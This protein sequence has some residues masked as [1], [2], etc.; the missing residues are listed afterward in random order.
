MD[1][2][3]FMYILNEIIKMN[4]KKRDY[5]VLGSLTCTNYGLTVINVNSSTCEFPLWTNHGSMRALHQMNTLS[6]MFVD[7]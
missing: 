3:D 2:N 6:D 5:G 7:S 4:P 1:E